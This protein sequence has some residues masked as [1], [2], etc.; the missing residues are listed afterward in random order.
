[1]SARGIRIVIDSNRMQSDELRA[2]LSMSP[3][4]KAVLTDYAAMEAFQGNT[5]VSI[6]ASWS[7]LRD[8]PKQ[9]LA[10]EPERKVVERYQQDVIHRR[11]RDEWRSTWPGLI[12]PGGSICAMG[13]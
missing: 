11:C 9:I 10:L 13:R 8:F 7:V 1:M 4:N 2:F 6:Q 5:L 12:P 3:N